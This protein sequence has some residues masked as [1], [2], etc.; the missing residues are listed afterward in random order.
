MQI[1]ILLLF[2][3][4]FYLQFIKLFGINNFILNFKAMIIT[5]DCQN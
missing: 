1:L 5:A 2:Q 3:I 4:Q